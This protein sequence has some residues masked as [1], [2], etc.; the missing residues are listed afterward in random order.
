[1][2]I[3]ST[4]KNKYGELITIST[5]EIKI[6]INYMEESEIPI[7]TKPYYSLLKLYI[8]EELEINETITETKCETFWEQ[9]SK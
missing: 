6:I 2:S 1:M 9:K 5:N 8:N 4:L 3:T 7:V